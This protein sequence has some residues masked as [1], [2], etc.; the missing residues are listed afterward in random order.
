MMF[1]HANGILKT[2]FGPNRL[3]DNV[4]ADPSGIV[5]MGIRR[6]R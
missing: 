6:A 2:S 5:A 1:I 4:L 3:S